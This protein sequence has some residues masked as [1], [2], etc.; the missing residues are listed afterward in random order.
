MGEYCVVSAPGEVME[1]SNERTECIKDGITL[2]ISST[3][4]EDSRMIRYRE[5]LSSILQPRFDPNILR[6]VITKTH[7]KRFAMSDAIL[8]KLTASVYNNDRPRTPPVVVSLD[9]AEM[10]TMVENTSP[11]TVNLAIPY[12]G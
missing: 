2:L 8:D 12:F 1:A 3:Q 4:V 5:P 11:F 10:S 9:H 7:S 6:E